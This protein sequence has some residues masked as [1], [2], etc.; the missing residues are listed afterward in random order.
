MALLDYVVEE[1]LSGRGDDLREAVIGNAVYRRDPP[2]D[3]RIDSTVRVEAR[4][5]RRKLEEHSSSHGRADPI[6]ITIPTGTYT[7]I[8]V[9]N[10][11]RASIMA[12]ID[13]TM[14]KE[15]FQRGP[16]TMVAIM[17]IRAFSADPAMKE[18]ADN[19]TDELIF[20]L[21]SEPG[22]SVPSRAT[23]FAYADKQPLIPQLAAELGLN[24]VLQGTV[25]EKAGVIKVTIEVADPKGFVV[26]S[27]RFEAEREG[28]DDLPERIATTLVSRLRFDSSK[29]RAK[30]ISPGPIA[31][32]SHA[33]VYRARQLLDR[34]VPGAMR[35]AL[36]I[37]ANVAE[38]APDYAR[39]HS[40][41]SDCHCDMFRIGIMDAP[42]ALSHARPAAERAL[43]IDPQSAEALTA[44]ATVQAWLERDR[45][46]AEASFEAALQFGY[47]SR[48]SRVYGSYLTV[49]GRSDDA[50]RMFR[51]ARR[52]EP[53]S[54]QQDIAEA[55]CRFQSRNFER[56]V[57][58]GS[59][60]E[61]RN[62]P[63]EALFYL[64]LGNHFAGN[65]DG[66][67]EC[68]KP[69]ENLLA[70]HPQIVF[71]D[72][73]INAW[74]GE[75]EPALRLLNAG[76]A[77]A[78]HFAHAS[79]ACAVGEDAKVF[80]HLASALANR[81]LATVWMRTDIRFDFVRD[82]PEYKALLARLEA[83]RLS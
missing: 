78:S 50:E 71:A 56:M 81:E 7:P 62:A 24:A 45:K 17:P 16:G 64:A 65:A 5:L 15:I 44:L 83:L 69:L 49:L 2:Y 38:T 76:N 54:Q 25:R 12:T 74:L 32:Q 10:D 19:L 41:I 77:K 33:K 36:A 53:F 11:P 4:R 23:T 43:E 13:D 79:L 48:T 61:L 3:P 34:Q 18:F 42:T 6:V 82:T 47:N 80:M 8:F 51:E 39:G 1:T 31:I 57:V 21:G 72:A 27:D 28:S 63:M 22:I 40:G 46:A 29:M 66:A 20:G 58:N 60:V 67:R 55:I 9:V 73:E 52:I 70:S 26:T 59:T 14:P 35:E 68:A 30:E 37:F 75:P